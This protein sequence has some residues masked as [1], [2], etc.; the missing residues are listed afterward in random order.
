MHNRI[1]HDLMK[2]K[3]NGYPEP[4]KPNDSELIPKLKGVLSMAY[5]QHLQRVEFGI[6]LPTF[7]ANLCCYANS[8]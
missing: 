2:S 6:G 3:Y 7:V 1:R 5:P 8:S 4:I